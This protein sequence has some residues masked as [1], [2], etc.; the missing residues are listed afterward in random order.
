M[1]VIGRGSNTLL[2]SYLRNWTNLDEQEIKSY[3]ILVSQTCL[4][5][6]SSENSITMTCKLAP[7]F[8]AYAREPLVYKLPDLTI[9]A[10]YL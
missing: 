5:K 4:K 6:A 2:H 9:P 8:S 1:R 3:K 10:L 7:G